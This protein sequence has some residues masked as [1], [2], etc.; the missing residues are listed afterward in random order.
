MSLYAFN[1]G[2]QCE[3]LRGDVGSRLSRLSPFTCEIGGVERLRELTIAR[4]ISSPRRGR[5]DRCFNM[6][7][8]RIPRP[9]RHRD[10]VVITTQ[11]RQQAIQLLHA[12]LITRIHAAVLEHRG[13]ASVPFS[14]PFL[15]TFPFTGPI[16]F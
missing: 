8:R 4:Y 1:D 16:L 13:G 11:G 5:E 14:W 9:T 12:G 7:L 3:G 6:A 10:A 15:P 2:G